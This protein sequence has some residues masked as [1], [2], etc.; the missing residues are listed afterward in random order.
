MVI[1]W[2]SEEQHNVKVKQLVS[3]W[4]TTRCI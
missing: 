4:D 1:L 3:G 2:E